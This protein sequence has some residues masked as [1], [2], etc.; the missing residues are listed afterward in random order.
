THD[1]FD[2]FLYDLKSALIKYENTPAYDEQIDEGLSAY[3]NE[4]P[5][6]YN[7]SNEEEAYNPNWSLD[8]ESQQYPSYGE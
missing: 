6:Q 7:S 3:E 2:R 4:D 8:S 1:F 5:L